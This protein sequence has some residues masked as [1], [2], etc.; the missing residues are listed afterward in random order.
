M[1]GHGQRITVALVAEPELSFIVS[2]PQGIRA[3][4]RRE[5]SSFGAGA[6]PLGASH[7]PMA[8]Q[9]GVNSAAGRNFY[10]ARQPSEEALPDFA[11][12]PVRFLAPGRYD[13]RFD[14]LGQL[15]GVS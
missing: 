11:R 5:R 9:D 7:Q 13:G 10:F 2:T 15:V 6:R 12:A 1:I 4:A 14:L 8:I 3:G